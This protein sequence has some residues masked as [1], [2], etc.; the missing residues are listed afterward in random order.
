MANDNRPGILRMTGS[1]IR[2]PFERLL[3]AE[4][5]AR[6]QRLS[7]QAANLAMEEVVRRVTP[8]EDGF[9][10]IFGEGELR[11]LNE[12]DR[13]SLREQAFKAAYQ[14]PHMVGYLGNLRRFVMGKGP[15]YTPVVDDEK[16]KARIQAWWAQFRRINRWDVLED[17]IPNRAWR[18]GEAFIRRFVQAQNGP[19]EHEVAQEVLLRLSGLGVSVDDLREHLDEVPK[20]MVLLRLL[21]PDQIRDPQNII[22]HGIVT[23]S[24]DVQTVLGYLWNH[25]GDEVDF[26]GASE[27]LHI[28]LRVDS[29][30]KRG[31]S[32]LE[33]LLKR[34]AQYDKWLDYRIALS[35]VR[36]AV[37][38]LKKVQGTKTQ[39][40]QVRDEQK[41]E[42]E[43]ALR[44]RQ[45]KM[46]PPGTVVTHGPSVEWEFKH[47][48][49]QAQDAQHDGRAILLDMAAAT[50]FPEYMFTGDASNANF[51]STMVAESPGVREFEDW[52]DT[53]TPPFKHI[54]RWVV[55]EGARANAIEG[56]GPEKAMEMDVEL[57]WPPMMSRDELKHTQANQIRHDGGI[58][59][60][61]GW[62]KDDGVEWEVEKERLRAEREEAVEF[63]AP[64]E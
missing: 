9:V 5:D 36:A 63:T 28:K 21:D 48:N 60:R 57:A 27:M 12:A 52:Q 55:V 10:P 30:V 64:P 50:G 4:E 43:D 13:Q 26:I 46:L 58:L 3:L 15:T 47:P 14:Q 32:V 7:L 42:R 6:Y 17:E 19:V 8:E 33:P 18:D 41:K 54:W 53:L 20:G 11:Q 38:L 1:L 59:S 37:V 29:D 62:A 56:L 16:L 49:I 35:L 25:S 23:A 51:A 39:V 24:N 31:R 61:E 40:T 2:A 34:D 22:S 44:E 45:Q